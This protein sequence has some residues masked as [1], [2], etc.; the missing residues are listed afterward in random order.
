MKRG[1]RYVPWNDDRT[2]NNREEGKANEEKGSQRK[3]MKGIRK[4][5]KLKEEAFREKDA[6]WILLG[7]KMRGSR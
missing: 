7:K 3:K 2:K 6:N 5:N 4:V 1:K